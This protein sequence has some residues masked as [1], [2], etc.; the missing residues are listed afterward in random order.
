MYRYGDH[1][2][3]KESQDIVP[4]EGG[5]AWYAR[6]AVG[7]ALCGNKVGRLHAIFI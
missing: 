2:I 6:Q 5:V 7:K 1:I 3:L 4:S